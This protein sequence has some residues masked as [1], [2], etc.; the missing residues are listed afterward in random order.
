MITT[1]STTIATTKSAAVATTNWKEYIG[2]YLAGYSSHKD[3]LFNTLE[4]AQQKCEELTFEDC[5]GITW[6]PQRG[7]QLR[8]ENHPRRSP[9]GENSYVRPEPGM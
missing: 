8:R 1:K 5:C 3:F 2:Y 6:I 9:R 7:Y 4:E